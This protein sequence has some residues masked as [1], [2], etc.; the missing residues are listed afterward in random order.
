MDATDTARDTSLLY[1]NAVK[2]DRM[3]GGVE[4]K[5]RNYAGPK[6]V[7]QYYRRN[8]ARS[9]GIAYVPAAKPGYH[10]QGVRSESDRRTVSR[11]S[12][13]NGS[14][15]GL[16][17]RAGLDRAVALSGPLVDNLILVQR[18]ARGLRNSLH[19]YYVQHCR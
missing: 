6:Q 2:N 13:D 10:D 16:L 9:T 8:L 19:G 17:F 11:K 18:V 5:D 15:F 7:Y 3:V 14:A 1:V 4:T 12:D